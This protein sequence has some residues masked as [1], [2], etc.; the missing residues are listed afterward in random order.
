MRA[1]LRELS[2]RNVAAIEDLRL[3]LPPGFIVLTGGTG[4]GKSVPMDA[5]N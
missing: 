4:A 2:I 5:L 3:E 1:G